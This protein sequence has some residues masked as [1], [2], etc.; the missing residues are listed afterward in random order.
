MVFIYSTF[1]S[2]T[3]TELGT[4]VQEAVSIENSLTLRDIKVTGQNSSGEQAIPD[5]EV[6]QHCSRSI[7]PLMRH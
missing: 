5:K 3:K 7:T 6:A 4:V 2:K 1:V